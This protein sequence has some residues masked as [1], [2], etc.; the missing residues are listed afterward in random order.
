MTEL[1]LPWILQSPTSFSHVALASRENT[2][3]CSLPGRTRR[4]ETYSGQAASVFQPLLQLEPLRSTLPFLPCLPNSSSTIL[5]PYCH[6]CDVMWTQIDL[7]P[8]CTDSAIESHGP[9]PRWALQKLAC[10]Q[11]LPSWKMIFPLRKVLVISRIRGSLCSGSE[12][13]RALWLLD[14]RY[15]ISLFF[16]PLSFPESSSVSYFYNSVWLTWIF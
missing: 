7:S 8:G 15:I 4:R 9:C 1:Q 16:L 12:A 3:L 14:P 6:A 10:Q 5:G 11:P 13:G 2:L